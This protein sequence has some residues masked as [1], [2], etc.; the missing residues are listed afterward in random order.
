MNK[1]ITLFLALLL[2]S[3]CTA[4][5]G[6]TEIVETE[7]IYDV[8][9]SMETESELDE[10]Q[11]RL[12]IPDDLPDMD[13]NG[14]EFKILTYWPHV[15]YAEELTGEIVNDSKY[16]RQVY[17]ND[18][19]N[20][21]IHT[22]HG[23]GSAELDASVRAAVLAGDDA[24]DIAIP[25]MITSG[26][27]FVTEN[28][29]LDL[30][31]VPYINM[32]KPW[33][34]EQ[35][36]ETLSIMG[37]RFYIDGSINMALPFCLF[38]NLQYMEDYDFGNIYSIV[39]EYKWTFDLMTEMA[40]ATA[41]DLNGDGQMTSDTDQFG[42]GCNNDNTTVNFMYA[43][44]I[45]SVL[46]D[47]NGMPVPNTYNDKMQSLVESV[48]YLVHES[49]ASIFDSYATQYDGMMRGFLEGRVM[50]RAG[51]FDE[52]EGLRD[53]EIDMGVIPYPMWDENQGYY[54]THCDASY[55]LICV[56]MTASDVER[57]GFILEA[58]AA[59]TYKY[60]IPAFYD[61]ALGTKA[62]RDEGS[63]EMLDLIF[64]SI[65]YDFGYVFDSWHGCTWTLPRLM[66]AGST[67]LTSY[68]KSIENSVN[69]HYKE[70]YDAVAK[71]H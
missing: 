7:S 1:R 14:Y 66:V 34:Y 11:A 57:T 47:D 53:S 31:N 68:W 41:V 17:M 39:K 30:N 71:N 6:S 36:N 18:V 29:I 43:A 13:F 46:I 62:V 56:P 37:K 25:H 63:A 15:Y 52:L 55:G 40:V 50:I 2:L 45:L 33:W 38:I 61:V 16:D 69:E 24:Y 60:C 10:E 22:V 59:Y 42:F 65:V 44:G 3:S 23:G 49:K 21:K 26:P 64:D 12:A 9:E 8:S 54:A 51:G 20:T 67:D 35:V 28:L 32:E 48:Y 58:M 4:G 19:Y 27:G 5:C 70:I